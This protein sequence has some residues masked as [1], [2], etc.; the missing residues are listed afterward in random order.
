MLFNALRTFVDSGVVKSFPQNVVKRCFIWFYFSS[1]IFFLFSISFFFLFP[2][3]FQINPILSFWCDISQSTERKLKNFCWNLVRLKTA[4][5]RRQT[6]SDKE[7]ERER[8][9]KR[10]RERKRESEIVEEMV[11]QEREREREREK[12]SERER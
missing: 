9:R 5:E 11:V 10:G 8:E 6:V 4:T 12:A 1:F 2:W 7:R 3:K